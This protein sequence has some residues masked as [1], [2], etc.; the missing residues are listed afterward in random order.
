MTAVRKRLPRRRIGIVAT[1][2]ALA[3]VLVFTLVASATQLPGS[4]FE[5]ETSTPA[6]LPG[7][8]LKVDGGPLA[9][10][11][12]T[13]D[14][15]RKPDSPSGAIDESFTQGT[16]EDTAVPTTVERAASRRTS[17][18][19]TTS[20]STS[21]GRSR[22]PL[23]EHGLAAGPGAERHDQHGLRVQPVQ[24]LSTNGVT[25]VRTRAMR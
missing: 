18:T 12:A 23:P 9:L 24:G 21:R 22:R 6:T 7:A 20:A 5:I 14:E 17:G 19:C 10:D 2:T 8:N 1:L 25:P 13:V 4:N 3:A 16:K 15:Q 11:W